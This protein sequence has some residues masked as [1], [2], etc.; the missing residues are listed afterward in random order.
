MTSQT[1]AAVLV[2]SGQP[3]RLMRLAVPRLKAGQVLVDVTYS[4]VCH[5]Q[6]LEVEGKRG[7]DRFLPHT[8]GHEGSGIV[9]EVG[10]EVTKVNPGDRVVLSWIKGSGAEVPSTVY[11]GDHG[12]VNSGAISTFMTRAAVSENRVTPI[13][14]AMPLKEAALL[15]CALPT[16]AGALL[17]TAG[18]DPGSSVAVFGIGG[19]GLSAIL[20]ASQIDAKTVIAVDLFDRKLE[21]A[22]Q[23][24]ATHLVNANREDPV[25][26]I[27]EITD[28]RGVDY[29][30]EAAGQRSAIEAAFSAVREK[31]G[32]C[33]VAGN[34]AQ[35]ER[36]SIDPFEL[37]KGKRIVGTW[38]GD[39][40]PDRDIPRYVDMYLCGKLNLDSLITHTYSLDEVNRALEDLAN[41]EVGRAVIDVSRG[42]SE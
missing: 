34:L 37:I 8:V 13:S 25:S 36:I 6:L 40:N 32:L 5:T 42:T 33:V 19:V 21:Q 18:A 30:I 9:V 4:G 14:E 1:E 26:A 17:N 15:G 22:R 12:Q 35:G 3:L 23:A 29:S 28:Q 38:G 27:M 41:G 24:G 39:T 11:R 31:G 2:E 20:A 10:M 16:G 7:P